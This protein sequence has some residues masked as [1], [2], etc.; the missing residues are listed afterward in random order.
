M[1]SRGRSYTQ[2]GL[3]GYMEAIC[4]I[5][6]KLPDKSPTHYQ[7]SMTLKPTSGDPVNLTFKWT[8]IPDT[9]NCGTEKDNVNCSMDFVI[10]LEPGVAQILKSGFSISCFSFPKIGIFGKD[11]DLCSWT[12]EEK[13]V[14]CNN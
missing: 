12:K 3:D 7:S 10:I 2:K 8:Y 11:P 14:P 4:G 13:G 5:I 6:G 9:G 1:D